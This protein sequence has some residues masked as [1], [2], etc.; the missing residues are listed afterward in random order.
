MVYFLHSCKYLCRPIR[1]DIVFFNHLLGEF[2]HFLPIRA[3]RQRHLARMQPHMPA[4][5]TL[6]GERAQRRQVLRQSNRNDHLRQFSGGVT[7]IS[8]NAACG[9]GVGRAW[10]RQ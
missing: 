4:L 5:D 2:I 1:A 8:F 6:G 9:R 3:G 10:H 7:F